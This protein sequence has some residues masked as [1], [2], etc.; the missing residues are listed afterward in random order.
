MRF[1]SSISSLLFIFLPLFLA[2]QAATIKGRIIDE[3]NKNPLEYASIRIF[4]VSDS[5][6]VS[7]NVTDQKGQFE[8]ELKEG[9][10]YGLVEFIGYK[11]FSIPAFRLKKGDDHVMGDIG[12]SASSQLLDEIIVQGEKSNMVISLD[13]RIFNVGKDLANAGGTA[14]DLLSNIPSLSVDVEGNVKLRGSDNV[15]ILIEGKP[16]GLVSFKGGAGLQQLQGSQVERVEIITNPSARYEAEG[17]SGIINIILKKDQNQGFN[18][19]FEVILGNPANYGGAINVNY[20][21]NKLNFFVNYGLAFRKIPG[22]GSQFQAV[23]NPGETLLTDVSRTGTVDGLHN[24]LRAGFDYFFDE[25]NIL[26]ASY[27]MRRTDVDRFTDIVYTDFLNDRSNPLGVVERFQNEIETEPNSE[28]SLTYKKSFKEKG[29]E[30]VVD[31]RYIDYWER[32]D[33]VFTQ[34]AFL[35]SGE[36]NQDETNVTKALNDEF[37]K[38]YLFQLDYVLPLSLGTSD[39]KKNGKVEFGMR[40]GFR[41]MI[42]DY[43]V[44]NQAFGGVFETDP[45]FDNYFIYNENIHAAYAIMGDKMSK[46]SYQ[47]GLRGEI[48]DVRTTLQKTNEVNPRKYSNLFPSGHISYTLGNDNA[49]QLSYSR[50]VRRPVY[51]ELSPFI[52][53]SDSRNFFSGN[54][55]LN[56][57][58][59]NA[60]DLGHIK[61]FENGSI[62]SSLYHRHTESKIQRIRVVDELGFASTIPQNLVDENSFGAE[63]VGQYD[64]KKWWKAD[65]SFNFFRAIT[66]GSNIGNINSDTYSWFVR[67][68][69]RFTI[70]QNGNLQ[71]RGN[72]EAPQKVPQGKVLAFYYLDIGFNKDI[73]D[74]KA[75]VTFNVSDV[76]NTRRNRFIAEGENFFTE[77]NFQGRRRQINLTLNYRIKQAKGK[78]G[79]SMISEE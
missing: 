69:S 50:R 6:F 3:V 20:R 58:F 43:T 45:L 2:S 32:S 18:G 64:I 26:T 67:H 35:P 21:K 77:G 13:K 1:H 52:T 47:F 37:E 5:A 30:L 63:F 15:R 41:D 39:G 34:N 62:S 33:Q 53:L 17:M 57:E 14:S 31:F 56:P 79:K 16:S 49:L 44:Q 8:V 68:T 72:Y 60:Y 76:F 24:N 71:M 29:K 28:A 54:P 65:V 38:T 4:N 66:D 51:N 75:T 78:S 40:S 11:D 25:K 36:I 19:S 55:D 9:D 61:Y 46:F 48:T 74:G 70:F 23:Y 10:F 27:M 22:L 12:V 59:S 7:G 73:L 42:N